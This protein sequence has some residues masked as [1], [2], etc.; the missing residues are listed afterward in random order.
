MV[1]KNTLENKQKYKTCRLCANKGIQLYKLFEEKRKKIEGKNLN[2]RTKVKLFI[3][4]HSFEKQSK[5]FWR[6]ISELLEKVRFL[7]KKVR[8]MTKKEWIKR[9]RI[10]IMTI[11]VRLLRK[12]QKSESS[13]AFILF[14]TMLPPLSVISGMNL[15]VALNISDLNVLKR[16]HFCLHRTHCSHSTW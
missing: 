3:T 2:F 13:A 8:I 4:S 14:C 5:I 15:I 12:S 9:N 7:R 1:K 10:R 6:K 11:K 16:S